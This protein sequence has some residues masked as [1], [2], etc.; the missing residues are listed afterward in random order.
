MDTKAEPA[1]LT[2]V[3]ICRVSRS[4]YEVMG[5]HTVSKV[6]CPNLV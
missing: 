1:L 6:Y 4:K 3:G 2:W 5:W